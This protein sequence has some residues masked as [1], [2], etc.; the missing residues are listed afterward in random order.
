MARF[1]ILFYMERPDQLRAPFQMQKSPNEPADIE[2]E[3]TFN[4]QADSCAAADE[5][6]S[7][8]T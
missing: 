1:P 4:G 7:R 6:E 5:Q 3:L 8:H 2:N